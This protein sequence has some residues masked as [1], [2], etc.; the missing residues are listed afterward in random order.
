VARICFK[1]SE[2]A[3]K[4][5]ASDKIDLQ[6]FF[7]IW[8]TQNKVNQ[9]VHDVGDFRCNF[10][11]GGEKSSNRVT[12]ARAQ[13]LRQRRKACTLTVLPLLECFLYD[14]IFQ[15]FQGPHGPRVHKSV[16][17]EGERERERER[18]GV[19]ETGLPDGIFSYQK[20]QFGES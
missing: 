17:L 18:D 6:S 12:L 20:S 2:L 4:Y 5:P 15:L 10:S 11:L 3:G 9:C 1:S 13:L 7:F 14:G 19:T 16:I 8:N